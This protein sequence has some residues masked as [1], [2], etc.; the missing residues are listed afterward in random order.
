MKQGQSR[1]GAKQRH[2]TSE[3]R[4]PCEYAR[5]AGGR[6]RSLLGG[7]NN[8]MQWSQ[9]VTGRSLPAAQAKCRGVLF[10]DLA[11]TGRPGQRRQDA[12]ARALCK[13][14]LSALC[15]ATRYLDRFVF[16]IYAKFSDYRRQS[17]RR[18]RHWQFY[19]SPPS[20]IRHIRNAW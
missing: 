20:V 6:T 3:R 18:P 9:Q 19:A 12:A 13:C 4:N 7:Q 2:S 5:S 11:H 8:G 1:S 17:N 16:L 10:S 15:L 14:G